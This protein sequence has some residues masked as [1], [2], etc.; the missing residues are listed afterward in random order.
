MTNCI[1]CD[2]SKIKDRTVATIEEINL[3]VT[4]GQITNGGYLLL[5][6]TKHIACLGS[7]NKI[8]VSSLESVLQKTSSLL[9][10]EYQ[11]RVTI[12]EHGIVGQTINHAH[13]HILPDSFNLTPKIRSDFPDC[14]IQLINNFQELRKLY[15]KRK[16][17]YLFWSTSL[18]EYLVC[19]NP[20]AP[21][22]YLRLKAAEL[23]DVPERGSW[24]KM[25][26]VLDKSLAEDT[27]R[28][29]IPAFKV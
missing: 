3:V 18:S 25:D 22:E 13:L 19:W 23:L 2:F 17:P 24:R 7:L 8:Q 15:K 29:L 28:R 6:P 21:P 5:I 4:L 26:S 14:E 1:F 10:T 11:K 27:L 12:F 20:P 9:Q 16:E